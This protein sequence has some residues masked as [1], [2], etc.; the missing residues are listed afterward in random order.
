MNNQQPSMMV[1]QLDALLTNE[2]DQVANMANASAL[3]Y[4]SM[5]NVNWAG[6]Y[7]YLP[8][9]NE[10]ILGPFQGKVACVHIKNGSGVC[11]TA[12]Q[13]NKIQRIRDVHEFP[14]HIACDADS[15]SEIVIPINL[16]NGIRLGVLDID[17]PIVN[18]FS[19]SDELELAQFVSTFV[20]HLTIA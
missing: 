8:D 20:K 1:Q 12:F 10:L 15:Q 14:G 9:Q 4:S 7:R 11:G 17:S 18:R 3:L 16:P 6:F 2:T 13:Q 5:D 19:E